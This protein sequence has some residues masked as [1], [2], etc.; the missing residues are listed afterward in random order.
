MFFQVGVRAQYSEQGH[1]GSVIL[2]ASIHNANH[3][4]WGTLGSFA[5]PFLEQV[6]AL[7]GKFQFHLGEVQFHLSEVR[8]HLG[9]VRFHLSEVRFH[10]GEVRV[11]FSGDPPEGQCTAKSEC[12]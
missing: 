2:K 6:R 11:L 4:G 7:F 9:E 5:N 8:F 12:I 1:S 3:K 10:V